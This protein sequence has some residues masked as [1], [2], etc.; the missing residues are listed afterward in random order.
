MVLGSLAVGIPIRWLWTWFGDHAD[1]VAALAG[2][3]LTPSTFWP[4][5][6]WLC[7][8]NPWLEQRFWRGLLGS[9]S[10][11]PQP[12]DAA[13]AGYHLLVVLP[14]VRWIWLPVVFLGLL[15]ASWWWR[16]VI[17]LE[18]R[19]RGATIA[20]F[21]ADASILVALGLLYAAPPG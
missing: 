21:L 6:L 9:P 2:W 16:Q 12:T 1:L 15:T 5:A 4:F 14:V 8:C 11:H 3:G 7:L 17:R 18:G 20:H 19:Y 10:R 13:F